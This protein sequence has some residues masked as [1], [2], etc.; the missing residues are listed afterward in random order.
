MALN[1]KRENPWEFLAR[2]RRAPKV[3][4][5]GRSL[6]YNVFGAFPERPGGFRNIPD[7]N[8]LRS[9]FSTKSLERSGKF[10]DT[11]KMSHSPQSYGHPAR[12]AEPGIFRNLRAPKAPGGVQGLSMQL[13]R[14]CLYR[15]ILLVGFETRLAGS[16]CISI[17]CLVACL[18]LE[19]PRAPSA[20]ED[21]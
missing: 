10:Q 8:I 4:H 9:G 16:T 13:S 18:S 21:S 14:I 7:E 15:C 6:L 19:P 5:A 3:A 12:H 1:A 2:D 17:F 11:P 20:P